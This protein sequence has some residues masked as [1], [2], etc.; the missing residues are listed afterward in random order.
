MTTCGDMKHRI[1]KSGI[2][3]SENS[4]EMEVVPELLTGIVHFTEMDLSVCRWSVSVECLKEDGKEL[5]LK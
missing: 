2:I 1:S 4:F 5:K 3:L